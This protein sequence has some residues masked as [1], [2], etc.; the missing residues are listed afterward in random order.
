MACEIG[1]N[2]IAIIVGHHGGKIIWE[3]VNVSGIKQDALQG[4]A[5]DL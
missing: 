2:E 5:K 3:V 1:L 4:I